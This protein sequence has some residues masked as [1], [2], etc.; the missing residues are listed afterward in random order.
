MYLNDEIV[1]LVLN[2]YDASKSYVKESDHVSHAEELIR[3]LVAQGYEFSDIID[4]MGNHD[5]S[6][7]E[8]VDTLSEELSEDDEGW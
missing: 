6:F 8:A 4:E 3:M 1:E 5:P 7:S 2:C